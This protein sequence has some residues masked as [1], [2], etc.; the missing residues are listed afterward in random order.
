MLSCAW[1]LGVLIASLNLSETMPLFTAPVIAAGLPF[2]ATANV[3]P[4]LCCCCY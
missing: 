1:G 2:A 3:P 4:S